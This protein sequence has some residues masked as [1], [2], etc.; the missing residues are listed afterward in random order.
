MVAALLL[1]VAAS[2][3]LGVAV[4]RWTN[5]RDIVPGNPQSLEEYYLTGQNGSHAV[6][7]TKYFGYGANRV[8]TSILTQRYW[9]QWDLYD[10]YVGKIQA[11]EYK[12]VGTNWLDWNHDDMEWPFDPEDPTDSKYR[13][14]NCHVANNAFY[15]TY[16][17]GNLV[18]TYPYGYPS[19]YGIDPPYG[20]GAHNLGY[21]QKNWWHNPHPFSNQLRDSMAKDIGVAVAF[22]RGPDTTVLR[23]GCA[24]WVADHYDSVELRRSIT[25]NGGGSWQNGDIPNKGKHFIVRIPASHGDTWWRR[26]SLA[27][28]DI[29][30]DSNAYLAYE[31][32]AAN[33]YPNH[34][35]FRRST[36]WGDRWNQNVTV[37]GSGEG[38][39]VAAVGRSVLVTWSAIVAADRRILYRRSTNGG[40]TWIPDPATTVPDTVPFEIYTPKCKY[41][42]PNVTGVPLPDQSHPGFLVVTRLRFS[43]DGLPFNTRWTTRGMFGRFHGATAY[44]SKLMPLTSDFMDR[45]TSKPEPLNPSIAAI[46]ADGLSLP[47]PVQPDAIATCVMSAPGLYSGYEYGHHIKKANGYFKDIPYDAAPGASTARLLAM[48]S[49]GVV[50][51]GSSSWPYIATGEVTDGSPIYDFGATGKMPALAVDADGCRWSAY[52][53]QDT[54]WCYSGYGD[55]SV[56]FAGSSSAVLG[57]PSI[58]TYPNQANGVYVG[59]VVF[60]VYD[61][62]GGSSMVMYARVDT[63][64]VVLDTIAS[65][66]NLGD[67]LPCVSCYLSDTL[68]VTFSRG[69][70]V[71][72]T[73]LCDY[74]PGTSGQPPAWT[75]PNLVTA[76]GYHAMSRFDDNGTVLNVVWSRN[77]G[78]NHAIQRAT[79]DLATTAFGNWSTMATPGD[80][81]TA[82]KANPVYA[83]LG[84]SCWQQKD[85]SGTWTIKGFVRGEEETFVANDT[86][87]YH[88]HCVAESSSISPSISEIRAHILYTAGVVFEVDS[89]VFDTGE[90]RYVCCSLDVSNATSDA[91]KCNNGSKFLRKNGSDSLFSVYSDL[92]NAVVFAWSANGDT[93]QRSVVVSGREYPAIA[94]DSSGRRW[95]VVTKPLGVGSSAIEAYYRSGSSWV[96]PQTLYTNAMVPLGPASLAGASYTQSGIGYAAFLNTSGMS[97]SV[98]LAKFD[99][100]NV[101]TYTVATGASLGDPAVTVEP[102]KADSDHV[103][104]TWTESGLLRYR[105]DTDGRSSGIANNWTSTYDL[106]GGGVTAQHPS[107]NSDHSQIVVAWAQGSPTDVYARK[108]STD[109]AYNNWEAAVNLSNTSQDGSD[110]PTIAM[111][112]TV[113]VAWQE[114]R[115]GG[116]DFDIMVSID[117]D[118]TL[119]IADNATFS[120]YPHIVFQN[121]ASGDTAIPYL[122]TVWSETP[123][124]EYYEVGYNKLNLKEAEGEGGQAASLTPIPAR[125]MLEACRPNPFKSHTQ[126]SYALPQAGNVSLQ[127]YDIT[128]RTVRRLASGRQNAGFY[129]VNWDAKDS[130]G[131]QVPYG[132]YFYRLDTPGFR[133][134]K[135]AV[136][137]R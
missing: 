98:I 43:V 129:T 130:H 19:G 53:E 23:R 15:K 128:G 20:G 96:G 68:V 66:Q 45:Y 91:T 71:M 30:G 113:V 70:S 95:V 122:H 136:V 9:G 108:R 7:M 69:D 100:T 16:T 27:T 56:V 32:T 24:V 44:W 111:G 132:V 85:A 78:S 21:Q 82:E 51:Y 79:C 37:L 88:P 135:K 119:N 97:T 8:W 12:D 65:A 101:S 57:Q 114:A 47:L 48:D 134:V 87:A 25:T 83:G 118:D 109:S 39:C 13:A 104:V 77:N 121:K 117:F 64:G 41:D 106:T 18:R 90:T 81:G 59:N 80:T 55:P 10:E 35:V 63:S 94:E 105:M 38:P 5:P 46:R 31:S 67:S 89:G 62:A 61:T 73:M 6:A 29:N 58:V 33:G 28:D 34:I 3:A 99:G 107:I 125:P 116:G 14:V 84:V 11:Y 17:W 1:C 54:L 115:T 127:V 22:F 123:E 110:W 74:G 126:I 36:D 131:R 50:H 93:W 26:P 49:D 76:N 75:S 42:I 2:S 40:V 112:D 103:H 102:Y 120:S 137:T 92:D 124:A 72:G 86:D 4:W 60:P 52:V 133:S